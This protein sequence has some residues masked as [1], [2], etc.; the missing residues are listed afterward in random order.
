M[1]PPIKIMV[2]DDKQLFRQG[3]IALL[4]EFSFIQVIGA[5]E[6]GKELLT[7][8]RKGVPDIVLLDIEMPVMDGYRTLELIQLH[9][10]GVKTIML[11]FHEE[12]LYI[13]EFVVRGAQGYLKKDDDI[14]IVIKAIKTVY[15]G[16]YFFNQKEFST[17][18]INSLHKNALKYF[19]GIQLSVK[20][21]EIL[22]YVCQGKINAEIAKEMNLTEKA[23]EHHRKIINEVSG[24]K[25]LTD[26]MRFAYK[27]GIYRL[28]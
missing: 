18:S 20:Q 9:F 21:I 1:L 2:A 16:S 15:A 19:D 13:N 22:R 23:I 3:L 11:S 14:E 17:T 24:S 8:I 5:A 26:L 12:E 6:D 7:Q 27:L 28:K 4:R 25:N 10:P